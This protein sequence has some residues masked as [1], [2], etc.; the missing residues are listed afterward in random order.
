M[1]LKNKSMYAILGILSLS[2]G[3]GYDIKKYCN[4]VLSGFWNENFGHIYPTLKKLL[5]DGLIDIVSGEKNARKVEYQITEKG[6]SAFDAWL[7][8]ETLLQPVRSEFMLKLLFSS[9]RPKESVI[10]MLNDYKEIH[11]KKLEQYLQMQRDLEKGIKEIAK[12]RSQFIKAVL[13]KG[14]ISCEGTI[15]WCEETIK[16]IT[17]IS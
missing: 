16:D 17:V 3:T 8:E 2:P 5:E 4:T 11:E 15:L 6:K 7:L 10:R 13:R 1:A 12:E 9:G 14:I